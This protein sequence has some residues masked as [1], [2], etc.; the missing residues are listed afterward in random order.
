[1]L[2]GVAQQQRLR[3][4]DRF[5]FA[6]EFAVR[7]TYHRRFDETLLRMLAVMIA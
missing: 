5:Y 7:P 2:S 4:P 3:V 1:M 6:Y